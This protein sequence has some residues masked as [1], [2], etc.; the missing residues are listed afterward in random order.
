[1]PRTRTP[2]V[3][4]AIQAVAEETATRSD[5]LF[6]DTGSQY[7]ILAEKPEHRL[8]IILKSQGYSNTEIATYTGYQRVHINAILR[9]PWA[10]ARLLDILQGKEQDP[11]EVLLR[12]S[13]LDN[14]TTLIQVRDDEGSGAQA[15]I[16]ASNSLLDR[17][18]GKPLQ[19]VEAASKH[20]LDV[21][22]ID[23]ELAKLTAE[24]AN[25]LGRPSFLSLGGDR[26]D[27]QRLPPNGGGAH[28]T[29]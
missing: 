27:Q 18:L 14:I 21:S 19:R 17:Y 3:V 26:G 15:R 2:E 29:T 23:A 6:N 1:M 20:T 22:S 4:A 12:A 7:E 8:V 16:A 28:G 25:L 9:Q 5:R 11:A 13:V 24:E 10:R